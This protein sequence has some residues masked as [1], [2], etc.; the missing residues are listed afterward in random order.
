MRCRRWTETEDEL[1]RRAYDAKRIGRISTVLG[2][3]ETAV[4][5]RAK[6]LRVCAEHRRWTDWEDQ[7][8]MASYPL[9]SLDVMSQHLGRTKESIRAHVT[10]LRSRGVRMEKPMVRSRREWK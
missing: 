3:T 4:R 7:W 1:M 6:K 5:A 8:L 2:R 10:D 9:T